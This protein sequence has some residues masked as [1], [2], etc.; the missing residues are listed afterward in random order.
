MSILR[1]SPPIGLLAVSI[2]IAC[3]HWLLNI[4]EWN[5]KYVEVLRSKQQLKSKDFPKLYKIPL[6]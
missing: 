3:L 2:S 6:N 1:V 5:T 4:K